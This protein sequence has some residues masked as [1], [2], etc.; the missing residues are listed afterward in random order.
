MTHGASGFDNTGEIR[1]WS[2][3]TGIL[4]DVA[5]GTGT[6]V[7]P[8]AEG[9]GF[10]SVNE[11]SFASTV[12]EP[13]GILAITTDTADNDNA[14]LIAGKF[15]P[16]DG[17]CYMKAR[18]KYSNTD[19]AIFVGFAETMALDTP[20]MPAEFATATMTYNPGNM[21]GLQYDVDGTTDDFRAVMGDGSAALLDSGNGIR[22]NATVTA[23][24]WFEAEVIVNADGSGECWLSDVGHV[25][26][27]SI[28]QLRLIKNFT[29]RSATMLNVT[30]PLYA[31]LMIENRSGNARVLEV[32]YFGALGYRDR[33]PT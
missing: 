2:D 32:D 5:W 9:I 13:G 29:S 19:C 16:R 14:A 21:I 25:D 33:R 15:F 20:V 8:L 1:V 26:G 22:A 17:G 4:N 24:R 10:T 30:D 3:F 7:A 31:V 12:D 6:L 28:P 11:G 18:F 23:D 27:D